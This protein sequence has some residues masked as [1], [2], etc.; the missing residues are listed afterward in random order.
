MNCRAS[1]AGATEMLRHEN[2]KHTSA[3]QK[4]QTN[5]RYRTRHTNLL[6]LLRRRVRRRRRALVVVCRR[7]LLLLL[8]RRL[9][10]RIRRRRWCVRLVV[11][12]VRVLR[13]RRV[14][15][16]L[17][18]LLL[19]GRF[20][21]P[22]VL[23]CRVGCEAIG[24]RPLETPVEEGEEV[25]VGTLGRRRQVLQANGEHERRKQRKKCEQDAGKFKSV[26]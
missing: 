8:L 4:K 18:V 11:V 20:E 15:L 21:N 22:R 9:S 1:E 2:G 5:S 14:V 13:W 24:G 16:V 10:R 17:V 19:R 26:S 25:G 12:V 7:L 6:L 3:T 23:E